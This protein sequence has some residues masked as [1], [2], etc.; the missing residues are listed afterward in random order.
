MV[1]PGQHFMKRAAGVLLPAEERLIT[2]ILVR[3]TRSLYIR[4]IAFRNDAHKAKL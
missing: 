1:A 3:F 4:I 2:G